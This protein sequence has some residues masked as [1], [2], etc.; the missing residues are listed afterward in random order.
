MQTEA[1]EILILNKL[2]K[3]LPHHLTYHSLQH[4][5]NVLR[6]AREL[7]ASEGV[8]GEDLDILLGLLKP[9]KGTRKCH[10]KLPVKFYLRTATPKSRLKRFAR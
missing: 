10:A 8:T 5:K 6:H 4:T 1:V 9:T 2:E 7:A 3:E